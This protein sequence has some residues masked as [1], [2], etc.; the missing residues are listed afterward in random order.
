MMAHAH[1]ARTGRVHPSTRRVPLSRPAPRGDVIPEP[2]IQVARA[3]FPTGHPARRRR[4]ARGPS[5]PHPPVAPLVS[6]TGRPA[7]APAQ[8]ARMTSR[9]GAEGRSD[10]QAAAAVRARIDGQDARALERTDPGCEASVRGECRQRLSTGQAARL[11]CETMVTRWRA[12]GVLHATGRQRPDATPVLAAIQTRTRR[13]GLGDT[14]RQALTVR[15][16]VAPDG[17]QSWGP[18][19]GCARDR[20]RVA[21]SRV[22]PEKPARDTLATPMGLDGRPRLWAL[23][24]PA[25]PAWRREVPA[26]QTLRQVWRPPCDAS[27][28][29][30]PG[31]WRH[32]DDLPPAPRRLRSPE[33]PEAR[34]GN[35]RETA[36]TGDQGPRTDPCE[37]ETPK[38]MTAV[39]TT[40]ATPP[41][42]A[43]RPPMQDTLATRPGTPR[44]PCVEAGSGS[45]AHR[46]TRRTAQGSALRGPVP[47]DQ[48]GPGQAA[49]GVAAAQ[50][51]LAWDAHHAIGPPGPRRVVGRARP[52]RHGHATVRIACSQ[53]GGA[54]CASRADGPRAA[55]APRALRIRARAH[56]TVLQAARARQPTDAVKQA[57]ARRAGVAGTTAQGTRPG[58]LR[59]SRASG[60]VNTQRRPVLLAAAITFTRAAAWFMASP[61]A[62][63]RPSAFAALAAAAAR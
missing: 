23:D 27:P 2:T 21:D 47:G 20:P 50:G 19:V 62:R 39:R 28:E 1:S 3:A 36:W 25:T 44:A 41:E 46:L 7:A 42:V 35:T 8:R 49:P 45:A 59:R 43:V 60:F 26:L 48:R 56:A 29:D 10:G 17:R 63:T 40:P 31:R 5:S 15:A 18:A 11:R 58:E 38:L 12:Q 33:D 37:D 54:A 24:D 51:V 57:S 16:T 55:T 6:P 53:P 14:L 4:A 9:P 34:S 22:P 30:P 52:A 13:E 32:A 61:R